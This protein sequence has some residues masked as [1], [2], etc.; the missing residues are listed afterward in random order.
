[1][2]DAFL[3]KNFYIEVS[4]GKGAVDP[5]SDYKLSV[6]SFPYSDEYE[7]EP[8]DKK[9]TATRIKSNK[10]IGFISKKD[11]KDFYLA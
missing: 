5:A 8:N 1:M 10:I 4:S 9:E 6:S 11:D 7:I 3:K 2:P